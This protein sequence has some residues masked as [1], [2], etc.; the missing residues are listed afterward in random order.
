M[1]LDIT[2]HEEMPMLH[3]GDTFFGTL[4]PGSAVMHCNLWPN[5]PLQGA[6]LGHANLQKL[7]EVFG[8]RKTTTHVVLQY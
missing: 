4:Q 2:G 7:M 6:S 3:S 8:T 5:I 1:N